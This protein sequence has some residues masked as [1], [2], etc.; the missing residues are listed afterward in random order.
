MSA[1]LQVV[2]WLPWKEAESYPEP[3][4]EYWEAAEAAVML[5]IRRDGIRLCGWEHQGGGADGGMEAV[6]GVPLFNT[7]SVLMCSFRH[8]GALM[9]QALHP[10]GD[11]PMGYCEWAWSHPVEPGETTACPYAFSVLEK[12]DA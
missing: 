7:G 11:D 6:R 8:W 1:S 3:L 5:A 4:R 10:E 9:Y 12:Q 2:A